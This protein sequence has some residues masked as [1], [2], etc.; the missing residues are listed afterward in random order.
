VNELRNIAVRIVTKHINNW[1]PEYLFADGAPDDE[2][3]S[4]IAKIVEAV[5][6]SKDEI[7]V[8]E[9]IQD[10]FGYFFGR[11]YDFEDCYSIAKNVWKELYG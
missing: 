2:Y 1:D 10:T 4:E 11:D 5:L 7:E 3:E 6:K 9:A 8:A